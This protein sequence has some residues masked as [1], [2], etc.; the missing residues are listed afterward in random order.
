MS[1]DP[2]AVALG[3]KARGIKKTISDKERARRRERAKYARSFRS[4]LFDHKP[5]HQLPSSEL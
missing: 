3:R 5:V 2:A 4:P 1:K